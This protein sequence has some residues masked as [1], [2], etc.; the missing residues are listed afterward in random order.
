MTVYAKNI[1][2]EWREAFQRYENICGFE[3]MHQEDIDTGEMSPR[4][5][6]DSN[7]RWLEDV[8]ADVINTNT[9]FDD[10]P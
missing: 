9:P 7:L 8:L 2:N 4:E 3:I 1:S 10:E 6:W 5:A